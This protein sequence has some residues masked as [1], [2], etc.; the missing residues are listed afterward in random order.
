MTSAPLIPPPAPVPTPVAA[1]APAAAS[2]TAPGSGAQ[3]A[4]APRSWDGPPTVA[5]RGT[6]IVVAGRGEHPGVYER[7]GTRI[8]FDGYR[9]RAVGDPTRDPAGVTANIQSLLADPDLPSPRVLA[10]SDAGAAFVAALAATGA[11]EVDALLLV[12]LPADADD[13]ARADGDSDAD[14]ATQLAAR[15]ACPTH[16]ARLDADPA[17]RRD[18]LARPIPSSWLVDGDLAKVTVPILGLHGAADLISPLAPA[19]ARYAGAPRAELVTLD[20]GRHDALNDATHRSAAAAVVLFLERL[21][22]GADLPT[23]ARWS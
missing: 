14:W 5:A 9:V 1:S 13:A 8:A 4:G 2:D 11:V 18:D 12:G 7:F 6:V 23:I 17:V 3:A 22:L 16:Q 10:G 15:T 20:G 19:R 21:R